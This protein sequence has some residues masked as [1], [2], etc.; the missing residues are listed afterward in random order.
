MGKKATNHGHN[1][2]ISIQDSESIKLLGINPKKE[3]SLG[4]KKDDS[5]II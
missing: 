4:P 2:S 1:N 3:T 5:H